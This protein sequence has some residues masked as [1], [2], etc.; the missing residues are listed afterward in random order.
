MFEN[1]QRTPDVVMIEEKQTSSAVGNEG[2]FAL[3]DVSV[4][5]VPGTEELSVYVKAQST[6]V[7]KVRLR[8]HFQSRLKGQVLGD[9]WYEPWGLRVACAT[10]PI[11]EKVW[12]EVSRDL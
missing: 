5:T 9:A 7:K 2:V 8:W 6:P 10:G 3:N 12:K 11:W 1:I 4:E